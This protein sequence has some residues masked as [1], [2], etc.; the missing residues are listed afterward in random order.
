MH[1]VASYI[2]ASTGSI[3]ANVMFADP[4]T[5]PD[6]PSVLLFSRAIE[7]N[8][9]TYYVEINDQSYGSY[10]G[11]T[12]ARISRN[13][14][15]INLDPDVVKKFGDEKFANVQVAF[16]T[17]DKTYELVLSTLKNIFANDIEV[18]VIE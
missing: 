6:E 11:L 7:F 18:L 16:N 5:N 12:A 8:D 17:D 14:L 3:S 1:F 13:S 9:S 15:E 4:E 10:G 2:E